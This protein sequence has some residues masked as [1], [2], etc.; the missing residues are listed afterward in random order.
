MN[1]NLPDSLQLEKKALKQS[2]LKNLITGNITNYKKL[3]EKY[4]KISSDSKKLTSFR[5]QV[6]QKGT[7]FLNLS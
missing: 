2:M 6:M 4:R 3:S 5:N 1:P 7:T